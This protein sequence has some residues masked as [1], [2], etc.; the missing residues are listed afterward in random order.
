MCILRHLQVLF[1]DLVSSRPFEGMPYCEPNKAPFGVAEGSVRVG[2]I[3]L[4]E[5]QKRFSTFL[6]PLNSHRQLAN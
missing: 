1:A 5:A 4:S 6:N 2:A 3:S